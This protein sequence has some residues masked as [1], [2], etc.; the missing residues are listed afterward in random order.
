MKS[1]DVK[2]IYQGH[3]ETFRRV[4]DQQVRGNEP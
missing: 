3:V 4:D 1:T 2:N